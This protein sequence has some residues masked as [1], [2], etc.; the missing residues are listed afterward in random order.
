MMTYSFNVGLACGHQCTYCS[1]PT[2][3]RTHPGLVVLGFSSDDLGYAIVDKDSVVRM[4]RDLPRNL[5]KT[6]VVEI[7]T[8]V[9]AWAPEAREFDLGRQ[10]VLHVL[11][12]SSAQ[13][14]ILTKNAAIVRDLSAFKAHEK[15]VIVGLSTGIPPSREDAAAVIEPLAS[16]IGDRLQALAAAHRM[17]FRTF[18][19]LCP[20]LPSLGSTREALMEMFNAVIECG[21]ED[22]WLE[23]INP[24]RGSIPNTAAALRTA[25]LV[26]EAD[27]V[28]EA[29]N[30]E[31]W[32][33]Y[34]VELVRTAQ[35][36]ATD[37]GAAYK[38]HLLLYAKSLKQVRKQLDAD[39][40]G[41][42]WLES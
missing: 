7:C 24:R 18:G 22:I 26:R 34:V 14:R 6:D 21:V 16:T 31:A 30:S 11:E 27:A 23:P 10:C 5:K 20:C 29:K 9:D 42:V 1:T 36:V 41:L 37:L 13:V 38:L 40:L 3:S 12:H 39:P 19:M 35:F 33:R 8:T 2:M 25:G 4:K 17:G 32:Q 28:L 15:R